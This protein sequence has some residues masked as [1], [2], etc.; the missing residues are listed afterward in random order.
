MRTATILAFLALLTACAPPVVP[1]SPEACAIEKVTSVPIRRLGKFWAVDVTLDGKPAALMLDTGATGSAL[2]TAAQARLGTRVL[3]G[4]F[5]VTSAA[6][7][8]IYP[9]AFEIDRL[10]L[11]SE[12]ME[13]QIVPELFDAHPLGEGYDGILGMA[14]FDKYDI[15]IDMPANTLGLYRRRYCPAGPPPWSGPV[16]VFRR[17]DPALARGNRPMV[18]A[19]LDGRPARALLDTG[20]TSTVV[21]TAFAVAVGGPGEP[22]AGGQ[23]SEMRTVA[24]TAKIWRHSFATLALAGTTLQRPALWITSLGMTA[25][26]IIGQDLLGRLR[27][28]ISNG[29]DA[30]YIAPAAAPAKAP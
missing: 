22:P 23:V 27:I 21:D 25:D 16:G 30:V 26:M 2:T 8:T 24:A 9:R 29:S 19:V 14:T 4:R 12:T 15:E 3:H 5:T 11:G 6:G 10:T 1:N 28:W 17:S 7:G 20:A 18:R 13:R